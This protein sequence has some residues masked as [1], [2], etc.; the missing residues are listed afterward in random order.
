MYPDYWWGPM[1]GSVPTISTS[2]VSTWVPLKTVRPMPFIPERTW[3]K[4]R[5]GGAAAR[6][7]GPRIVTSAHAAS[8]FF[9]YPRR[10]AAPPAHDA[11]K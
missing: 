6:T 7:E 8:V 1:F 9:M 11:K 10:V 2:N 4:G 5:I 3:S